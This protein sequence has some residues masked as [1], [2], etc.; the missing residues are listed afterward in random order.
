MYAISGRVQT[1]AY[2]RLH[3]ADAYGI[4]YIKLHTA[5]AYG[6]LSISFFSMSKFRHCHKLNLSPFAK[7]IS[8]GGQFCM[9]NLLSTFSI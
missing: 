8:P 6:I 3:T 2:I 7:D 5:D 1:C 4:A 9:L